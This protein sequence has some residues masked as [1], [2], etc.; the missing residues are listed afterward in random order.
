MEPSRDDLLG[1]GVA[2]LFDGAEYTDPG[3]YARIVYRPEAPEVPAL[4]PAGL[5]APEPVGVS[6]A[7]LVDLETLGFVGRPLFLIG[8]LYHDAA[9]PSATR[10]IQYLARD[11]S[12]EE[13]VVR[14]FLAEARDCATWVTFNGR[15]FDLPVLGLR[16]A[17][18]SLPAPRPAR[19]LDLLPVARR[20]WG[21]GLPDCRLTTLETRV[22]GRWRG[23]DIGGARIPAAYHAFVHTGEPW[24]MLQILRHNA[25][26]LVSLG[27]L[28]A[29]AFK[30]RD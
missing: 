17:Y 23:S 2:R 4:A 29:R 22:C 8:A 10:L 24:E 25:S 12:E 21:P 27:D 16:A 20:I 19:H 1:L 11:Y 7:V 15:T 30:E 13:A 26:D 9:D 18:Y 14:A 28:L 6:P 5:L 3:G